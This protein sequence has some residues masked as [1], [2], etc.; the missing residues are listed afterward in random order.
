[1][2]QWSRQEKKKKK[3]CLRNAAR[4][5]RHGLPHL[6]KGNLHVVERAADLREDVLKV[7]V[8]DGAPTARGEGPRLG[9][10][11]AASEQVIDAVDGVGEDLMGLGTEKMRRRTVG[12][13][14][15]GERRPPMRVRV[16]PVCGFQGEGHRVQ[17]EGSSKSN[18]PM[19]SP[20]VS[21]LPGIL[22]KRTQPFSLAVRVMHIF[23]TSPTR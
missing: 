8:V 2:A 7:F 13:L 18:S 19:I 1:M 23:I 22:L 14:H 4:D 21:E 12:E 6:S 20:A 16:S 3:I 15:G 5:E 11:A 10:E 17:R 9:G